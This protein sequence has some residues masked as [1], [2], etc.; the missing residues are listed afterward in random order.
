MTPAEI[1][2]ARLALGLS[3][4]QLGALLDTDAGTVRRME[5]DPGA[6]TWR[7]PAPRM[8]RLLQA[9]LDGYR[10]ADWP[11]PR[12]QAQARQDPDPAGAGAIWDRPHAWD[13]PRAWTDWATGKEAT[14]RQCRDCLQLDTPQARRDGCPGPATD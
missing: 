7:K 2:A 12:W 13:A 4:G 6:A 3:Q 8:V 1:R 5:M 11:T 10:P 9:Y 14:R